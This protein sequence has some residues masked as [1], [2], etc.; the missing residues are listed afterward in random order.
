MTQVKTIQEYYDNIAQ[1]RGKWLKRNKYYHRYLLN[2]YKKIIPADATILELGCGTGNLIG[3]LESSMGVG[4]DISHRMLE[5][6]RKE[7]P[8]IEFIHG[9]IEHLDLGKRTF[10]YIIISGTLGNLQN[11]QQFLSDI[12]KY[13]T[14]NTRLIIDF[15]NPLWNPVIR[16]G[17]KLGVKMPEVHRNWLSIDD[18]DNF[19]YMSGY[20][21]I[22]RNFILL[23]PK[24]IPIISFFLNHFIGKLPFIRRF[25]INHLLVARPFTAPGKPE[26]LSASVVIT[27]R[28]EEGN[29]EGLVERMPL[30]GANTEIIFVEGHS[31]DNTVARI[32]EMIKKYPNKDIKLLKQKGIGQGDAFRYGFDKATGD[33]VMWLE[34]DLTTPPEEASLFWETF[35]SGRGEYINGS[36]FIYKM[37]KSAM[38]L[39]N[40]LGNRFFWNFIYNAPK[41]AFYRYALWI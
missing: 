27:C 28:D 40:F 32:E 20:Q 9:D 34:A 23:F 3:K 1:K 37:K 8:E 21:S 33:L 2:H 6:A 31:T 4:V 29:I 5:I 10:D 38:P 12:K 39:L 15:Y 35:V 11:I 26:D 41:A 18:I 7:Y 13:A 14:H 36:R 22:K 17:Q 30:M 19:L 24:F 16:L 25:S